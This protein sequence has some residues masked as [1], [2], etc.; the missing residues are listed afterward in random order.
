MKPR[1]K[2]LSLIFSSEEGKVLSVKRSPSKDSFP[3]FW[4][5]P[6]TWIKDNETSLQAAQRLSETKLG[7]KSVNIAQEPLGTSEADRN[8]FVLDMS[9]YE[10]ISF[11]GDIN[12]NPEEY[13][14]KRWV[15]P[16]ELKDIFDKEYNG[17]MGECC[18]AFLEA[19]G[20]VS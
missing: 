16:E 20:L 1:R 10:V 7:L 19:K 13:T 15:T 8:T 6:S 17:I 3:N 5:L 11:Q 2:A 4:S 12:L 18:R 14:D 9:D